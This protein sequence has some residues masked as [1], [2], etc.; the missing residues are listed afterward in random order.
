MNLVNKSEV[1]HC[2]RCWK[3]LTEKIIDSWPKAA[4]RQKSTDTVHFVWSKQ[5]E[6]R[7]VMAGKMVRRDGWVKGESGKCEKLWNINHTCMCEYQFHCNNKTYFSYI[8]TKNTDK[9]VMAKKKIKCCNNHYAVCFFFEQFT[10]YLTRYISFWLFK[11]G[12][13]CRRT[14]IKN[15]LS[16]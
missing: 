14:H 11:E 13:I 16:T 10:C 6:T 2:I 5:W 15:V 12:S 1:I 7:Y 3:Y 4:E 9:T 8:I